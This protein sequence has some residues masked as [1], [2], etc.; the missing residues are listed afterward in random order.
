[1]ALKTDHFLYTVTDEYGD[2]ITEQKIFVGNVRELFLK[3]K[4]PKGSPSY[5]AKVAKVDSNCFLDKGVVW[6]N[7]TVVKKIGNLNLLVRASPH[8]KPI[9]VHVNDQLVKFNPDAGKDFPFQEDEDIA[10]PTDRPVK[11]YSADVNFGDFESTS[12]SE[13]ESEEIA[14]QAV[15]QPLPPTP[16]PASLLGHARVLCSQGQEQV[17]V[18]DIQLTDRC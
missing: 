16:A 1:M 6:Y 10:E 7:F 14:E 3:N 17:F 4:P 11:H 9:L 5:N 8:S 12:R 15:E 2:I 13:D 18:P